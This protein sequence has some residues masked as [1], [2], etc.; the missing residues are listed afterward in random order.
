MIDN[1]LLTL[2][3]LCA[4]AVVYGLA[5]LVRAYRNIKKAE[6]E[7]HARLKAE[8]EKMRADT[9]ERMRKPSAVPPRGKETTVK[10]STAPAAA[11]AVAPL[12]PEKVKSY[13]SALE[14]KWSTDQPTNRSNDSS[15]DGFLTGMLTGYALNTIMS[16]NG[17]SSLSDSD[18]SE[19]SV[20][21][22]SR[23]SSWGFD[24][25]DSRKSISDSMSSSWSSSDSSS[26]SSDS[27]SSSDS[28]P[29][30]DW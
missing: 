2:L 29:S 1:I 13:S 12:P 27:W 4:V 20:G 5:R 26:S 7:R 22:S 17:H 21:V 9:Y 23:E 10:Y 11:P 25:S 8:L 30:S 24:D 3:A 16:G 28:G 18:S 15:D 6:A 14:R 19:R